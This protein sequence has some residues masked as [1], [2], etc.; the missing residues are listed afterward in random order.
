MTP[1]TAER[2]IRQLTRA[3]GRKLVERESRRVLG[4]GVDEF[5]RRL[6]AGELDMNDDDVLALT[7]LEPFAR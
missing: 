7:M 5:L 6:D 2:G 4:I 1:I 3:E